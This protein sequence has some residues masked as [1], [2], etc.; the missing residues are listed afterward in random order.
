M[1]I[2]SMRSQTDFAKLELSTD[3]ISGFDRDLNITVWNDAVVKK[4]GIA[5]E[6]ALGKNLLEL[7]PRLENENDFRLACFRECIREKKTFFFSGMPY[8][9]GRGIYTQLIMPVKEDSDCKVLSVVTDHEAN[10]R[11]ARPDLLRSV[12]C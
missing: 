10:K 5:K 4:Y 9:Y 12:S 6:D 2:A 1:E 3:C 8:V 11:Y 7:F